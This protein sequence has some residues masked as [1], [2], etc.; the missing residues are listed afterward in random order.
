MSKLIEF[1]V[2]AVLYPIL[3]LAEIVMGSKSKESNYVAE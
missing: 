3:R 2:T 1:A